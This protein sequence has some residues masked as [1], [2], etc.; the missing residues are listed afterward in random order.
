M[1]SDNKLELVIEVQADKANAQIKGVNQ[2]LAGFERIAVNVAKNASDGI[3]GMTASMVKGSLAG[4]LLAETIRDAAGAVKEYVVGAVELAAHTERLL[5]G[6]EALA[7][8]RGIDARAAREQVEAIKQIG[9]TTEQATEFINR[10]MV[11]G[12]NLERAKSLAKAAKDLYAVG[13]GVSPAE[14]MERFLLAIETGQSRGLRSLGLW[15][16]L[17]SKQEIAALKAGHA[18]SHE[19][20]SAVAFDAVMGKLRGTLGSHAAAA[21][22]AETKQ[23]D[24]GRA[25]HDLKEQLGEQFQPEYRKFI[26]TMMDATKWAKEHTDALKAVVEVV[27]LLGGALATAALAAKMIRAV[28]CLRLTPPRTRE[29]TRQP[30]QNRRINEPDGSETGGRTTANEGEGAAR[31]VPRGVRRGDALVSSP[32]PGAPDCLAAASQRRR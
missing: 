28:M 7:R 32:V 10:M 30:Q 9:Y 22:S 18:L 3:D 16:D 17:T 15:V 31:E 13:M 26:D 5:I 25:M 19:E 29:T 27:L 2:S 14:T 20:K 11:A 8:S 23:E 24:L 1:A 6:T 12:Q 21:E 4:N